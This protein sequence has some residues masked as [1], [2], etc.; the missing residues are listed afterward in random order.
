VTV[1][2]ETLDLTSVPALARPYHHEGSMTSLSVSALTEMLD[3]GETPSH[4]RPVV[5]D[6]HQ[7]KASDHVPGY[8]LG[9]IAHHILSHGFFDEKSEKDLNEI[10][11]NFGK[12][13]GL[14]SEALTKAVMKTKHM[15]ANL[16]MH[17]IYEE[18]R[19]AKQ[20]LLEVPFSWSSPLGE[21]HGVIDVLYQNPI[22]EW[23][24]VDWKTDYVKKDNLKDLEEKYKNQISVY[25]HAISDILKIDPEVRLV[26]LHPKTYV[27]DINPEEIGFLEKLIINTN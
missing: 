25:Y 10:I 2:E 11:K 26:F 18:I 6:Q 8:I 14:D 20:R 23:Y 22:G 5:W 4:I 9:N 21:V 13:E 15:L 19:D 3:K 17:P 12:Q 7:E 16:K 1:E 24:L 27:I